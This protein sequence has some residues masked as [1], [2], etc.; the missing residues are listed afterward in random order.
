ME[1]FI[2]YFAAIGMVVG[3]LMLLGSVGALLYVVFFRGRGSHGAS[4]GTHVATNNPSGRG[5]A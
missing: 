3:A 1:T 4:P 5:G 2:L